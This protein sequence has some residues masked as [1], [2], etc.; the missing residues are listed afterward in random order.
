MQV[1]DMDMEVPLRTD[2][3]QGELRARELDDGTG[4]SIVVGAAAEGEE[5]DGEAG[6][7]KCTKRA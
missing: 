7:A 6:E 1:G 3:E 4:P 5:E 2:F